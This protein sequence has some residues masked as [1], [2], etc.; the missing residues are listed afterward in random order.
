[1]EAVIRENKQMSKFKI[2]IPIVLLAVLIGGVLLGKMYFGGSNDPN[3]NILTTQ[4]NNQDITDDR[5]NAITRVVGKASDCIVGINVEEV[6][7]VQ[8][9]FFDDPFFRQFF[10]ESTPRTQVVRGLGSGFI[11]SEDGYRLTNDHSR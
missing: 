8:N 6:Q 11:I 10:G 1:M 4:Q 3:S 5:Q 2:V 7:E 9:P